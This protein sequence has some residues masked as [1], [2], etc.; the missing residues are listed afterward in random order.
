LTVPARVA[1]AL[2]AV[3][4][5]AAWLAACGGGGDA[6]GGAGVRIGL[7]GGRTACA[8]VAD[9]EAERERGLMGRRSLAPYDGMLFEFAGDTTAAFWMK[10]T[11]LPLS[12]AW[13][14]VDGAL[15]ATTDMDTCPDGRCPLYRAPAPYRYAL[16]VRR[17]SLAGVGVGPSSVLTVSSSRC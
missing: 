7:G 11:P 15:L 14:G 2:A 4:A 5:A 1:A 3:V 17:G 13:F 10:D 12:I 9:T 16:E 6:A 8:L